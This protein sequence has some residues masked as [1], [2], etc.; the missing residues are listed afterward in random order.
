VSAKFEITVKQ[1]IL[2]VRATGEPTADE[3]IQVLKKLQEGSSYT[4]KLRLWD[5]RNADFK[6]EKGELE[7][8]SL[9]ASKADGKPGKVAMLVN[10]DLAFALA[11]MYEVYRESVSTRVEVFRDESKAL[12]WLLED[13]S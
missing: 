13:E 4:H 12:S 10:Q 11:R 5:Y 7:R 9:Q 8:V 1:R 3:I 6:L 2:Y